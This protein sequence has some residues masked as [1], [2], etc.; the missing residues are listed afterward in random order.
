MKKLKLVAL[1]L[2][3]SLVVAHASDKYFTREGKVSFN[4]DAP[5]EKIE[6]NNSKASSVL[7]IATGQMEFSVLM[8]AFEFEKALMQEHFNENYVESTKFP[9]SIFKGK[10]DN[11]S[12][13][14]FDKDGSYPV[15]VS[16]N[17]T[18][19]GVTKPVTTNGT[20]EV[21]NGKIAAVSAF[22]ILLKDYNIEIPKLVEGKVANEVKIK[23]NVSYE[24]LERS[25]S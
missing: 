17:L 11:I 3:G 18:L 12:D 20:I 7:D 13:V 2:F 10:V 23:V 1:A 25:G 9:K 21:K 22:S 6:A 14:K 8:K 5:L 15:K 4:S 19:H 16:G 24:P